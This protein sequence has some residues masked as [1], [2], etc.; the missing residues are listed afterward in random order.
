MDTWNKVLDIVKH[1]VAFITYIA[2]VWE[3]I[4]S[5][6]EIP[7]PAHKIGTVAILAL[8]MLVGANTRAAKERSG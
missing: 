7:E 3:L 4:E 8:L 5:Y 2:G 1:P 6:T